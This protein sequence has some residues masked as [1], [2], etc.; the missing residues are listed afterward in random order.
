MAVETLLETKPIIHKVF[1]MF[2]IKIVFGILFAAMFDIN[3]QYALAVI[4]YLTI[5]D[6]LTGIIAAKYSKERTQIQSG[7]VLKT[8]LK[9]FLYFGTISSAYMLERANHFNIGADNML[10]G[11]IGLTEFISILE[12]FAKFGLKL[13]QKLLNIIKTLQQ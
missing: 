12:N 11:I 8:A 9:V 1:S 3:T 2:S 5:F 6:F 13:P 4:L 10:I 7:K